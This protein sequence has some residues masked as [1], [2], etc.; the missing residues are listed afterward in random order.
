MENIRGKPWIPEELGRESSTSTVIISDSP[1][2]KN[3][4]AKELLSEPDEM[5]DNTPQ[6]MIENVRTLDKQKS[7]EGLNRFNGKGT[8][9]KHKTKN[10]VS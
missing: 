9:Q 6:Y 4:T 3:I 10:K 2:N 7:V 1:R 5:T 8:L